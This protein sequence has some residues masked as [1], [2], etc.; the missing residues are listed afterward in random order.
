MKTYLDRAF[1]KNRMTKLYE[2][3]LSRVHANCLGFLCD[4]HL[5]KKRYRLRCD[6][7]KD[8]SHAFFFQ[9]K[10]CYL[11]HLEGLDVVKALLQ[12]RLNLRE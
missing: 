2:F 11:R 4:T 9:K 3:S 8:I 10:N 7:S 1:Q 6:V 5:Y 12:V